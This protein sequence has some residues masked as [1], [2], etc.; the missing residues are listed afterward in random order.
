MLPLALDK[1]MSFWCRQ[2]SLYMRGLVERI[3]ARSPRACCRCVDLDYQER[4]W[5]M[6]SDPQSTYLLFRLTDLA[7]TDYC[8]L[9]RGQMA[10]SLNRLIPWSEGD[11]RRLQVHTHAVVVVLVQVRGLV[12]QS[13]RRHWHSYLHSP[14]CGEAAL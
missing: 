5:R 14:V 9:L 11:I 2:A 4:V 8:I 10:C 12:L 6:N 1:G 7:G 13:S 3:W